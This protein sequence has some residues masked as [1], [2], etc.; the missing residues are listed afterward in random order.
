MKNSIHTTEDDRMF[1]IVD[2]L[3]WP[4]A[5]V[6][7]YTSELAFPTFLPCV[8]YYFYYININHTFW[9]QM[10]EYITFLA[11]NYSEIV[12]VDSIGT[13]FQNRTLYVIKISSGGDNKPQ[14]LIDAGIHAREWIAPS[15][16]L[17]AVHQLVTNQS[18][19][20]LYKNV[21][22]LIIPSLNPDGYEYT[23][24]NVC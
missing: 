3:P 19:T 8:I 17:Y 13:S 5:W 7:N 2:L 10:E 1:Q 22:W 6:D 12:S 9:L 23:H 24:S 20:Y 14:I 15:T 18:N 21:D 11:K 16:A 4:S